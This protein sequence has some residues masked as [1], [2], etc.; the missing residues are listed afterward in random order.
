MEREGRKTRGDEGGDE[1]TRGEEG[2]HEE[3]RKR[4]GG[5]KAQLLLPIIEAGDDGSYPWN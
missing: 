5:V 4:R 3:M 1:K 2:R